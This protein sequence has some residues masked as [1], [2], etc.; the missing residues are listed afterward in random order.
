MLTDG[1][2]AGIVGKTLG[3][4]KVFG[5]AVTISNRTT[6]INAD[7][8]NAGAWVGYAAKGTRTNISAY[9]R[10]NERIPDDVGEII[11]YQTTAE[12]AP[13]RG[14]KVTFRSIEYEVLTVDPDPA[15]ATWVLKVRPL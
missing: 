14:G 1:K 12:A 11:I 8:V 2:I 6:S 5:E 4:S 9:R 10:S 15:G 3:A 13:T 7:G